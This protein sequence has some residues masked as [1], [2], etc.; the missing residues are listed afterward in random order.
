MVLLD[1]L[2]KRWTLRIIWELY[3]HGA[4]TFREL[5]DRCEGVSPT[6]LNSR[7]KELREL[8]LIELSEE[9]YALTEQGESLSALLE[10]VDGWARQ[11]AASLNRD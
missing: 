2:G 6:S 1:V 5:R 4:A 7:L 11:W 10:P 9:G 8:K 3:L